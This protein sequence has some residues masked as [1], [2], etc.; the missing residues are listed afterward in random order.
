MKRSGV[1]IGIGCIVIAVA[2]GVLMGQPTAAVGGCIGWVVAMIWSVRK[3]R[4]GGAS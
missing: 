2:V 1:I 3:D 4:P